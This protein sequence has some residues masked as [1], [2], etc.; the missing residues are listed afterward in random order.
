ME[1]LTPEM[2][3]LKSRLRATWMAGD[4]GQIAKYSNQ[5]A[6]EF[7]SGLSVTPGVKALDVACGTGNI[8]LALARRGADVTGVDI[9]PNLIEQARARAEAE[10]LK[11]HFDEGDAERLPYEDSSFDLVVTMFGAMFAPRPEKAA[12]ELIRVCRPGG[13]VSMGN[14]TPESFTGK[15][16]KLTSKYAPPPPGVQPPVLWGDENTVRERLR[17]GVSDL[18]L[19]RRPVLMDFPFDEEAVVDHFR[20]YFGPSQRTFESLDPER[21]GELKKDLVELWKE[22]NR[23]TDGTTKVESEYLEVVATRA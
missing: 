7:I 21:Q 13:I 20:R 1:S 17:E 18:K 8:S 9:A 16:F 6:D 10:G 5:W 12:A 4:F 23:A 19:T 14:W 2:E 11:A 22:H 3:A 15:M